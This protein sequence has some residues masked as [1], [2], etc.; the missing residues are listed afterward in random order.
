MYNLPKIILFF[1]KNQDLKNF[2]LLLNRDLQNLEKSKKSKNQQK[3]VSFRKC[4][5]KRVFRK[6]SILQHCLHGE[7]LPHTYC[8]VLFL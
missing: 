7:Y 4:S 5:N 1:V 2:I 6:P 3:L 8:I